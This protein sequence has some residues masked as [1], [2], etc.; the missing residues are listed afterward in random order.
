MLPSGQINVEMFEGARHYK[1]GDEIL[2][3]RRI[4]QIDRNPGVGL[5]GTSA[6]YAYAQ[7]CWALLAAGNQSM[8]VSQGGI[9]QAVLKSARKLNAGAGEGAA[10]AVG[11]RDVEP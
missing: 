8:S 6:L 1:R 3:R 9:P 7:Q 5:T 11:D 4:V 2:N 10:D